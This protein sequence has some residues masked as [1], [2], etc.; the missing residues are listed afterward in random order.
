MTTK[1]QNW[2]CHGLLEQRIEIA[3]QVD[4]FLNV[5][6]DTFVLISSSHVKNTI[7]SPK[8]NIAEEKE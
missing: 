3:L 2:L 6:Q 1:Y 5:K 4:T 7:P 8:K